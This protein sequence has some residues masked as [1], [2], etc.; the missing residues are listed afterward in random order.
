MVRPYVFQRPCIKAIVSAA[1]RPGCPAALFVMAPGLGKT[2]TS[3]FA[4]QELLRRFG[5]G[6]VLFLCHQ[7]D[8]LEQAQ[9]EFERVCGN[10]SADD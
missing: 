10:V 1:R 5:K 8:I 6:R 7:N 9:G 4:V 2:I 3:A